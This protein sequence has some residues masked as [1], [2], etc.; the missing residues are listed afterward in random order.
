MILSR[1]VVP[2]KI[3]LLRLLAI[4][5]LGTCGVRAQQNVAGMAGGLDIGVLA[6]IVWGEKDKRDADPAYA[7][8]PKRARL[9]FLARVSEDRATGINLV[10]PVDAKILATQVT[11]QLEARGFRTIQS[12]QK[13]DIVVT[14]KYGRGMLF[15]P[16]TNTDD[17][18]MRGGLSDT[19]PVTVW[20]MPHRFVGREEYIQ[21]MFSPTPGQSDKLFI[22]VRAWSYPPPAN[23]KKKAKLLWM[24]TVFVDDPDHR[25]LNVLSEKMLAKGAVYFDRHIDKEEDV[26]IHT[27]L[28]EGH[29]TVGTPDVVPPQPTK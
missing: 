7:A 14:V 23:P 13:P 9:F 5:L 1:G 3:T 17:D 2:M 25:D 8:D 24:T 12:G 28:P 27:A 10:Q 6:A 4:T 20:I 18:P 26:I 22:Q 29:V 11:H 15:N 19:D 16:Y 21:R